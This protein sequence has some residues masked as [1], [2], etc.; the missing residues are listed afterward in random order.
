[1]IRVLHYGLSPNRGG[2]ENY[3]YKIWTHIDKNEFQFEFADEW[4]GRTCYRKELEAQGCRFFDIVPRRESIRKNRKDWE[5]V[6]KESKADILHCHLNT[7]SYD[8]PIREAMD[9]GVHIIVHSRSAGGKNAIVTRFLHYL[10]K[11]QYAKC[12]MVRLAVSKKAGEWLFGDHADFTVVNNGIDT[13]KFQFSESGREKIRNEFGIGQNTFVLGNVAA[14]LPVKNQ[15]FIVDVFYR[16]LE[17]VSDAVLILSGDGMMRSNVENRIRQLGLGN[18][19][20]LTGNRSDIP[21][22]LSAI[23][24]FLMPSKYEGFPNAVLEAQ[25]NGLKCFLSD[26]ITEEVN[27]GMC[28]YLP[29]GKSVDIWVDRILSYRRKIGDNLSRKQAGQLVD[30]GGFSVHSEIWKMET[31]YRNLTEG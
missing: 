13:D 7:F 26:V 11:S 12:D 20:I 23:D 6:L 27:A 1:M 29:I 30:K 15:S 8:T 10:H 21:D 4:G 28:E 3:L 14:F 18:K 22:I 31:I 24:V 9:T 16:I 19:V 5:R 17:A 25:T 2:I